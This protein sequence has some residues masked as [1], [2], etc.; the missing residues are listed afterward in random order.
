MYTNTSQYQDYQ[1][2]YHDNHITVLC[3]S[4]VTGGWWRSAVIREIRLI[5][6]AIQASN[7]NNGTDTGWMQ[8]KL[9]SGCGDTGL[10][11]TAQCGASP[12]VTIN[13]VV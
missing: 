2:E 1:A 11:I 9:K 5:V 8:M 3:L 6:R 7:G 4:P 13:R 12:R 10:A